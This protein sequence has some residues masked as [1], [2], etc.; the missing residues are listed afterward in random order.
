[1]GVGQTEIDAL[2]TLQPLVLEEIVTNAM[3]SYFDA[4]L[5]ARVS[6]AQDEWKAA[7]Q[8][9]LDNII[10]DDSLAAIR[11][12]ATETFAELEAE[13]KSI[14]QQLRMTTD[15]L[16]ELPAVVIPEPKV[17][18]KRARLASLISSS[19]SWAK[20]TR[21]LISRKAYGYPA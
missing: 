10:D 16:F 2:A 9:I 6:E 17:D 8:E 14:N 1:L 13:V 5:G 11:Q 18:E 15:G 21:A 19:W 4:S 12:R 3:G 20:A 7:A